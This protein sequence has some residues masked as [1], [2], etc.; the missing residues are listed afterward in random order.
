MMHALSADIYVKLVRGKV[1]IDQHFD[2]PIDLE[3]VSA[4]A[5]LSSFHFHRLFTK[6]YR[7][8]PH[9][10]ITR[11][12]I[13]KAKEL[14]KTGEISIAGV[15][16]D[17]GFESHGS[18]TTLFKKHQGLAPRIYRDQ[19]QLQQ[20]KVKKQPRSFIP[21]CFLEPHPPETKE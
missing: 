4:N 8:T 2:E 1:F 21:H 18:F 13:D 9:Q 12:R 20:E 3:T 7:I 14:L 11:K 15:C 17:V 16:T 10:Y 5:Y 6:V 19:A